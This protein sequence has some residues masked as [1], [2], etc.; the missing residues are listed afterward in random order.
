VRPRIVVETN[1]L[2]LLPAGERDAE[3][4][5]ASRRFAEDLGRRTLFLVGAA[6]FARA[7]EVGQELATDL[8]KAD[9]FRRVRFDVRGGSDAIDIFTSHRHGLLSDRHREW[10]DAGD[11]RK[12]YDDAL[13]A[14]YSLTGLARP[15]PLADDPL[16]LLGDFVLGQLSGFG[17]TRLQDGVLAVSDET[18]SYVLVVAESTE[19][20][21]SVAAQER[22][23]PA[24]EDALGK[25]RAHPEV[26]V[27]TSG[28]ILHAAAATR[29]AQQEISSVGSLS[30]A[31]VLLLVWLTFRSLRPLLLS[32]S[33]LGTGA[34]CAITACHYAFGSVHLITLVFGTGLIGVAV[35]YS[36]HFLADQFRSPRTWK[37]LDALSH[38][39]PSIVT[40]MICGVLGYLALML[41]PLPGL[42]QMALFAAVGLASA[43]ATVLFWYPLLARPSNRAEPPSLLTA[44][45]TFDRWLSR[46][47]P[48]A[49]G[50]VMLL[51]AAIAAI[52][53]SRLHFVDDVRLLQSSPPELLENEA[54]ARALMPGAPDSRF[55]VVRAADAE[56]VLQA[57]ERLAT[58]LEVLI[59]QGALT[60]FSA[61]SRAVPSRQ[62]QLRNR[63]RLAQHVY[64]SD[65][66]LPRLMR[67]LGFDEAAIAAQLQSFTTAAAPL[68]VDA[69]LRSAG[70]EA[71]RSLWLGAIGDGM[72]SV[73]GLSGVRDP[74]ALVAIEREIPEARL[75]DKVAES[76]SLMRR[77]RELAAML[78]AGAYVVIA[79]LLGSRYGFAT[80]LRLVGVPVGAALLALAA[81]GLAGIPANLFNVLGLFMVLGLGIDYAVFLR[82][83]RRAG[84]AGRAATVLAITL[85]TIGT[86]LAYGLLAFSATPFIRTIGLTLLV[87]ISATYLFALLA[88][89]PGDAIRGDNARVPRA[90]PKRD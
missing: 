60:G 11:G 59:A 36:T 74:A 83:G 40:G 39:G 43:C 38:V 86:V 4:D 90:L 10:L 34:L 26:T 5:Q 69:W 77:Y 66:E 62:R 25:A 68:T 79:L 16:N 41:A 42:R 61:T 81:F 2:A 18:R 20:P 44:A 50:I 28:L 3:L 70:G 73:I 57:E 85:S 54:A 89:S 53:L 80:A 52:G 17:G 78:I 55:F 13:R 51:L 6:E 84:T 15:L 64:S 71:G 12:L 45:G 27:L 1:V 9:V 35:D 37:P 76:S 22:L 33:A 47:S 75:V 48:R 82:E 56:Q 29:R 19:A 8:R 30:M 63:E 87:G 65:G 88:Q 31:G 46:R 7:R 72:A 49:I 24:I 14:A 67:E 21:F 58:R 32:A 23:M